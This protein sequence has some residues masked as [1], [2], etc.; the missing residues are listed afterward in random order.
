MALEKDHHRYQKNETLNIQTVSGLF[1][2]VRL[3]TNHNTDC[4]LL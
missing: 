2:C 3:K 1:F 4:L